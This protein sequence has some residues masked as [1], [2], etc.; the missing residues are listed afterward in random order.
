MPEE[1]FHAGYTSYSRQTSHFGYESMY[2]RLR[3]HLLH[4]V[5]CILPRPWAHLYRRL[6]LC[7]SRLRKYSS[8]SLIFCSMPRSVG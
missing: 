4:P 5:S 1:I 2:S 6:A 7:S 8:F 3:N